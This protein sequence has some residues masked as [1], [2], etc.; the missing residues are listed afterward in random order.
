MTNHGIPGENPVIRNWRHGVVVY[1]DYNEKEIALETVL[2]DVGGS[3]SWSL[4]FTGGC[5]VEDSVLLLLFR[6]HIERR[7]KVFS[8]LLAKKVF[9]TT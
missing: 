3:S 4:P 5:I 6:S 1:S 7:K 8:F 2:G 9:V